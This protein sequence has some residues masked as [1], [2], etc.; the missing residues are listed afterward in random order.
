M[1]IVRHNIWTSVGFCLYV[2]VPK[3][4]LVL[5]VHY[6]MYFSLT[7]L[8]QI[9]KIGRIFRVGKKAIFPKPGVEA[10]LEYF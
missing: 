4:L 3:R 7:G 2:Q 6:L 1:N 9:P 5:D 8:R 10:L